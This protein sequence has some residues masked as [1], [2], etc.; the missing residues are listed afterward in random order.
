MN[1]LKRI[2]LGTVLL[3]ALVLIPVN[4]GGSSS[5]APAD[6]KRAAIK[7][8]NGIEY[9]MITEFPVYVKDKQIQTKYPNENW[10]AYQK[11]DTGDLYKIYN[12]DNT[13]HLT[14]PKSELGT[15]RNRHY[16]VELPGTNSLKKN[17]ILF[18]GD[19]ITKGYNG[20]VTYK[21]ASYPLWVH[22]Y[23][24]TTVYKQGH[25]RSSI[26]GH[27][28][29]DLF[30]ILPQID[31]NEANVLVM[32]Y[33]TNDYRHSNAPLKKVQK[34][35]KK[36]IK[37]IRHQNPSLKIYAVLP[38]PRY[39]YGNMDKKMGPGGY[40]FSQLKA[41]L[42]KTYNSMGIK[43]YDVKKEHPKFITSKNYRVRYYDQRLHPN[44][45]TYQKFAY[46]FSLWLEKQL[47]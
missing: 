5:H 41:G 15:I 44:V 32:G 23:L 10:F 47:D 37:Y 7:Q 9:H 29:N 25:I 8:L 2:Y 36:A 35:L 16:H 30:T 13:I 20:F 31:F 3:M 26:T 39:D 34:K 43:T 45:V 11:S 24:Q 21:N 33:G 27:A 46:Y 14:V 19:S 6:I 42:K 17:K 40:T 4:T 12:G 38:L 28:F 22:K 1:I 18:M